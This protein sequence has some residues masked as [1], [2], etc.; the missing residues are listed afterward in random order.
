MG[1][2]S[3]LA[4]SLSPI[5]HPM[6]SFFSPHQKPL[7]LAELFL[8]VSSHTAC[9][10]SSSPESVTQYGLSK[11]IRVCGKTFSL[12]SK[13]RVRCNSLCSRILDKDP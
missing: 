5:P 3:V 10:P 8:P 6:V 1:S 4:S 11:S 7:P 13:G 12:R 2:L 9:I